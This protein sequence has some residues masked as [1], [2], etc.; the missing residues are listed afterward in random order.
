MYATLK[1]N[2]ILEE[3]GRKPNQEFKRQKRRTPRTRTKA[4]KTRG[5]L[6]SKPQ[7]NSREISLSTQL[8]FFRM[9]LKFSKPQKLHLWSEQGRLYTIQ[10]SLPADNRPKIS[11]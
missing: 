11:V 5:R 8:V 10:K 1:M 7:E 2:S 3:N 9:S 4:K 6:W